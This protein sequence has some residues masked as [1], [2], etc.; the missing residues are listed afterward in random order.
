MDETPPVPGASE[1]PPAPHAAPDPGAPQPPPVRIPVEAPRRRA[2]LRE[3]VEL[4]V[5]A[6]VLALVIRHWVGEIFKIPTG[7]MA[8]T[9][10]GEHRRV[11]CLGC[12]WGIPVGVLDRDRE[13][14]QAAECPYCGTRVDIPARPL[15]YGGHKIIANKFL[16]RLR[17]PRRWEV[18]VFRFWDSRVTP[19]RERNFIKR[20]WGLPGER[21]GLRGGNVT[22]DGEICAK[23]WEIQEA[24][25]IPVADTAYERDAEPRWRA[26]APGWTREP[27]SKGSG[28]SFAP[29]GE[30][31]SELELM[32]PSG[33]GNVSDALFYN[34]GTDGYNVVGDVK[35][36]LHAAGEEGARLRILLHA[37]DDFLALELPFGRGEGGLRQAAVSPD[38]EVWTLGDLPALSVGVEHEVVFAR[39]DHRLVLRIDGREVASEIR[40]PTESDTRA[41]KISLGAS[42][43]P[44]RLASVRVWRDIYYRDQP[45]EWLSGGREYTLESGQYFFMGDNSG[46][47][48]DSRAWLHDEAHDQGPYISRD[49]IVGRAEF[50]LLYLD[51]SLLRDWPWNTF[52]RI[53]VGRVR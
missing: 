15:P 32:F 9:L 28:W 49:K 39:Y 27:S 50:S 14:R 1:A 34:G 37:A 3:N 46:S 53:R 22:I 8:P 20:L 21:I 48:N 16:Y 4:F 11:R 6:V 35:V 29:P 10:F 13:V 5:V 33:S 26:D 40:A 18:S 23:P 43:A 31:W 25:W 38:R 51:L 41:A 47:S 7:S 52:P 42:G 45:S 36:A 12:G 24:I 2:T 30:G 17:D 44:L 19:P